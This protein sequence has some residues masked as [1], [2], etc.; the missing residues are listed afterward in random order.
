MGG[1]DV[2][3]KYV[4]PNLELKRYTCPIC[5]TLAQQKNS[6][7]EAWY[8]SKTDKFDRFNA[9]CSVANKEKIVIKITTCQ[10]C[11]NYHI[12]INGKML[13]PNI[14]NIP[15]PLED[16]P[17]EIKDLYN[18]ARNVFPHSKR[19][20]A[21]LL[22]LALQ[23]LCVYLGGEGKNINTDIAKLVKS[24][25]PKQVQM[26]LDYVRVTGNNSVHPGEMNI[27]DNDEIC[28]RLFKMLNFIVDKMII[29]P[30]EID[31]AFNFLP[32]S[33]KNAIEKRDS[34]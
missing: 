27:E 29:E 20:T 10:S 16:M 23:K 25:L 33:A 12:W 30:K 22:R 18:E 21:A 8:D 5:D 17:S 13:I 6:S 24:G 9:A 3:S 14:S 31:E 11:F 26:A 2:M 28:L 7:F 19:A 34:K 4:A 32:E 1:G 15:L